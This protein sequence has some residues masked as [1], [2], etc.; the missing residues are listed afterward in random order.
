[1]SI[2][3]ENMFSSIVEKRQTPR[4]GILAK[5]GTEKK[6]SANFVKCLVFAYFCVYRGV[7]FTNLTPPP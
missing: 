3:V 1:M 5:E 7:Y 6:K 4:I 2:Q